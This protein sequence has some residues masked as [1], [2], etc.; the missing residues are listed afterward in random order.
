[1]RISRLA[2]AC[3]LAC[4][5]FTLA[6]AA[7]N[8]TPAVLN[9]RAERFLNMGKLEAA[10]A[11]YERVVACCEGSY[12][13]AEAHND[14]GVIRARQGE[15]EQAVAEYEK[16]IA[17]NGYP[18]AWFNLGRSCQALY[19]DKGD[20]AWRLRAVE[21]Y[22]VFARLLAEGKAEAP[23]VKLHRRDL[24]RYLQQALADLRR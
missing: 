5:W 11:T 9:Q 3:V 20:E 14:L 24:E 23:V 13:A 19:A 10:R 17:I 6:P 22:D 12:E 7:D 18:L 15:P 21:A 16:A 1:M 2:L 8:A 4:L